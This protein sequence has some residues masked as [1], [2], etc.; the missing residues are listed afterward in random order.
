MPDDRPALHQINLVVRDMDAMA[1][2][3]GRIGFEGQL[4]SP[5]W[6]PHHRTL[7][8]EEGGIDFDL[9]SVEFAQVWDE[10]W[11][12][13]RTGPVIGFRVAT[14]EAVDATYADLVAAGYAGQQTPYDAFWGARYAIVS[15]P[16]G[17]FVGFM[18]PIDP[19]RKSAMPPPG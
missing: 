16:E 2:F 14:R 13:E 9:D 1:E 15:D 11:P 10:G 19:A 6:D 12:A 8:R 18:S 7:S 5:R 4:M 3:Y 17:N